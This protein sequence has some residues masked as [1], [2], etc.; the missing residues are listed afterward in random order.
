M[1]FSLSNFLLNISY[2]FRPLISPHLTDSW[3]ELEQPVELIQNVFV[4]SYPTLQSTKTGRAHRSTCWEGLTL[5]SM[6]FNLLRIQEEEGRGGR[7]AQLNTKKVILKGCEIGYWACVPSLHASKWFF[8]QKTLLL[9][10][11]FESTTSRN[12]C[13]RVRESAPLGATNPSL[14]IE[15]PFRLQL[16]HTL[17]AHNSAPGRTHPLG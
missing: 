8:V 14:K 3:L 1:N 4:N 7:K 11:E 10:I 13:W 2:N 15:K 9:V 5:T 12:V 6:D 17:L 16:T